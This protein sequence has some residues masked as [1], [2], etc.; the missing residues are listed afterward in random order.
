MNFLAHA[1]LSGENED[2]LFGNFVADAVKG[3]DVLN[4]EGDI[5]LGIRLHRRIDVFTDRHEVFR[6]SVARVREPFGKYAGIVV[7]IYYDHFLAR[8]WPAFHPRP[9]PL[10]AGNVYRILL[11]RYGL[12][13][14][15]TKRLLPFLITQNWLVGYAGFDGLARVFRGMDRRTGYGSGMR[16][17]VEELK[18]N[19]DDLYGD[20]SVFYPLISEYVLDE[21]AALRED[22]SFI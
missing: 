3:N 20:F 10:F 12:L 7:D 18:K 16:T 22:T 9:L 11:D 5:R 14:A 2:V 13:P 8:N 1:H 6:R 17:A 19:Y 4:F 21:M 15:R